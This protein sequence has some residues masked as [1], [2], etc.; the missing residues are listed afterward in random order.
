MDQFEQIGFC[1]VD[2]S[3]CPDYLSGK[4]PDCRHSEWPD[5]DPCMPIGC[6]QRRGIEICGQCRGFPCPD[7]AAFYEENESHRAAHARMKALNG[8]E[9]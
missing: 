5:G 2:C 4:C 1:G 8:G 6:C 3:V 7:M 9:R